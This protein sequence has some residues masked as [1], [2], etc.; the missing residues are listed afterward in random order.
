L[1][2]KRI[3][4]YKALRVRELYSERKMKKK[5]G[6]TVIELAIVMIIIGVLIGIVT[7]G[8]TLIDN[9]RMKRLYSLKNEISQAV[10]AY[11]EQYSYY[12]GDDPNAFSRWPVV[13]AAANGNGNGI[14]AV[15]V[16]STAPNF[17]CAALGTEQCNQWRVLRE[18]GFL[19]G[20]SFTN[21][22]H[23][24]NGGVAVTYHTIGWATPFLTHWIVFQNVPYEIAQALDIQYDDGNWQTGNIRGGTTYTA[25]NLN[26]YFRL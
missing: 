12:P 11:Y 23:P 22:S 16:S 19:G 10:Y 4:V 15:A 3:L 21:P 18:G 24:F 1:K 7:K 26:L 2:D 6:F 13:T 25:G 20:S 14:V 8:G 9:A 5:A 17:A